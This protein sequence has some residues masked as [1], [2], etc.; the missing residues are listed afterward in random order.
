MEGIVTAL[1]NPNHVSDRSLGFVEAVVAPA[2]VVVNSIVDVDF[3][4]K[5]AIVES[6]PPSSQPAVLATR[7]PNSFVKIRLFIRLN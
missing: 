4:S 3:I 5:L 7:P 1:V 2:V 6:E